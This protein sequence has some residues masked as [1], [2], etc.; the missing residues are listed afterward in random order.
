MRKGLDVAIIHKKNPRKEIEKHYYKADHEILKSLGFKETR[1]IDEEIEI[2]LDHLL[3]Y[4]CRIEK[5]KH[6]IV[7]NIMWKN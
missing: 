3:Y 5:K 2:M 4:K 7:K 1:N 6:V